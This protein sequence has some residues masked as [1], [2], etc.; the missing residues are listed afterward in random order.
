MILVDNN[1]QGYYIIKRLVIN[2]VLITHEYMTHVPIVVSVLSIYF[3][4]IA[5][6]LLISII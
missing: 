5:V 1:I 6:A 2:K 4:Y 3:I